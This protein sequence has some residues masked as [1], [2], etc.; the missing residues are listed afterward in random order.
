LGGGFSAGQR[1]VVDCVA[2]AEEHERDHDRQAEQDAQ[3]DADDSIA[4]ARA[5]SPRNA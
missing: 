4:D 1:R 3:G 5:R 2:A